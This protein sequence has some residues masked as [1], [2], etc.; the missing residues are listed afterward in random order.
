VAPDSDAPDAV[1]R[2]A[3]LGLPEL[4]LHDVTRRPPPELWAELTRAAR[5]RRIRGLLLTAAVL[6]AALFLT[7]QIRRR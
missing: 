3:P 2:V 4:V 1:E 5:R 7:V 6:A